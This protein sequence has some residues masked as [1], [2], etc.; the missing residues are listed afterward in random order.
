MAKAFEAIRNNQEEMDRMYNLAEQY[1]GHKYRP[2]PSL[3]RCTSCYNSLTPD[4]LLTLSSTWSED[5]TCDS[6]HS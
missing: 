4:D 2:L 5:G 6:C 3:G 1:V